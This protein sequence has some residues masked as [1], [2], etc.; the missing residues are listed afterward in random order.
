MLVAKNQRLQAP[1]GFARD[2][3]WNVQHVPE[4]PRH[5]SR[6]SGRQ[7]QRLRVCPASANSEEPVPVLLVNSEVRFDMA[8]KITAKEIDVPKQAS[9]KNG[10]PNAGA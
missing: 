1:Q 5:G 6:K 4:W 7:N 8:D 9:V 3:R 10:G 2:P